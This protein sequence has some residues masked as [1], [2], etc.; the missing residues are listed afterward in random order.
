MIRINL[1]SNSDSVLKPIIV[2]DLDNTLIYT[3]YELDEL[4]TYYRPGLK[5]FINTLLVYADLSIF[6]AGTEQYAD[7]IINNIETLCEK[8]DLF[9]KR[10]FRQNCVKSI[11][12][13]NIFYKN[14]RDYF[15]LERTLIVDDNADAVSPH[16][17]NS[18]IIT[19]FYG[20][21]DDNILYMI[22]PLLL[23]FCKQ[24]NSARE[25]TQNLTRT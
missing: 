21:P 18:I 5:V 8:K 9:K 6:T 4:Y 24:K 2:L 12:N 16:P 10:L 13:D 20:E 25:F 14:L 19:P 1:M 17:E 7:P 22:L 11:L 23:Q 3:D 15:P